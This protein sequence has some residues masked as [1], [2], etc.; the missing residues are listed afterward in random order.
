MYRRTNHGHSGLK[1]QQKKWLK[2]EKVMSQ[3][4]QILNENNSLVFPCLSCIKEATEI[5]VHTD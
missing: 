1:V 4:E 3:F 5:K 2:T